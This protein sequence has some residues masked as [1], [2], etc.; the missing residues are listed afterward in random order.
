MYDFDELDGREFLTAMRDDPQ[1]FEA[2]AE[3]SRVALVE[4]AQADYERKMRALDLQARML[5]RAGPGRERR[6]LE[7]SGDY[8]STVD[9][10]Y[11]AGL[12]EHKRERDTD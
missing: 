6:H 10:E 12:A 2:W 9:G 3:E 1:G 8:P 4:Q 11:W 5:Q 7:Q